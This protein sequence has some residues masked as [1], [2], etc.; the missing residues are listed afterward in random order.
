M[1][2]LLKFGHYKE[3]QEARIRESR[4]TCSAALISVNHRIVYENYAGTTDFPERKTPLD[5]SSVFRLCS[6]TKPVT[7]TAIMTLVEQGRLDLDERADTYYPSF[8]KMR[9][10]VIQDGKIVSS[11]PAERPIL[12]RDL[13]THTNGL[14]TGVSGAL[15]REQRVKE[16]RGLHSL[17]EAAQYWGQTL[18]EFQPETAFGYSGCAGFDVLAGILQKITDSPFEDYLKKYIFDPLGMT[19]TSHYL[20]KEDQKKI[21]PMFGYDAN[22]KTLYPAEDGMSLF[23]Y[24]PDS[25][26]PDVYPGG[27]TG[28]F[29]TIG[30]YY[31]FAEM[32]LG[33]GTYRDVRILKESTVRS[34]IRPALPVSFFGNDIG[35]WGLSFYLRTNLSE[36][37]Q[38]LPIGS[39]GWSG[40]YGTHF[41][42]CP[43]ENM[44]G[45]FFSNLLNAGGSSAETIPELEKAI[46]ASLV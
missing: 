26:R 1:L 13:L 41:F 11:V 27:G 19:H 23:T 34:M 15:D 35:N 3:L 29:G 8:S 6:M 32:L 36:Q 5:K 38:H 45:L 30:D 42:V 21:L 9:V 39:F 14:G 12:I 43:S 7:A 24:Y 37:W 22:K 18:L 10:A 40:A 16:N 33:Y 44:T 4:L 17:E 25:F 46:E 20:T 31:V 28:L 2:D